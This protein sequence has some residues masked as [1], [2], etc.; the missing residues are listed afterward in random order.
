M[1]KLTKT[2][3]V[4][5]AVGFWAGG[6]SAVDIAFGTTTTRTIAIQVEDT[7][8][9]NVPTMAYP[10]NKAA[11]PGCNV[12]AADGGALFNDFDNDYSGTLSKLGGAT[13]WNVTVPTTTWAAVLQKT[14]GAAGAAVTGVSK[15]LTLNFD[16]GSLAVTPGVGADYYAASGVFGPF[17]FSLSGYPL[18]ADKAWFG[19]A[20]NP[21]VPDTDG[22]GG[23]VTDPGIPLQLSC[24]AGALMNACTAPFVYPGP[25]ACVPG[26]GAAVFGPPLP[27]ATGGA[28]CDPAV[29][30]ITRTQPGY[31]ASS[32]ITALVGSH[33]VFT[34]GP[35]PGLP[36]IQPAFAPLDWKLQEQPSLNFASSVTRTVI[37]Q[38]EDTDCTNVPTMPYP[39]NK[40]AAP[41]CNVYANDAPTSQFTDHEDDYYGTLSFVSGTT[42][43]LA[44]STPVWSAVLQATLGASGAAVTGVSKPMSLNFD[45]TGPVAPT[46]APDYYA[47]TGVFG[48]FPFSLN[49]YPLGA[50]KAWFGQADNPLVPDTDGMGGP[51]TD[52]GIPLQLSC[53]AG[54]LMNACTAP[55][56]YPGPPACVPGFG[57]A[58]FGPPLPLATG[59]APCDP[60]VAP[61]TRT[62]PGFAGT[63]LT[64]LVG[65]HLVFTGGPFPGLPAIQPAFAPLD[66]Q[67]LEVDG[68]VAADT[69]TDTIP[70]AFDNCPFASNV[71][72]TDTGSV[73]LASPPDGIGDA[74]QCGD[75]NNDGLVTGTDFILLNRS[76]L[77]LT[78][79]GS[80]PGMPGYAKCD[81]NGS[82]PA[83]TSTDG[84]LINR[85]VLNLPPG[86]TQTCTAADGSPL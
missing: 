39:D 12:Y 35:F 82:T 80:L 66:L 60:A 15:T 76:A 32:L 69:D 16:T 23:P 33:L 84:I 58:V 36:A 11:A 56:V 25:P 22:M 52:P 50:D 51:V 57:A 30:P 26:F 46:T 7:P 72:Q 45:T 20:D 38:T 14:L 8:C 63:A 83:C 5:A 3:A 71:A 48:P 41:G 53:A 42:W 78:P 18:G 13:D 75:I 2:L 67:L 73:G 70:N 21:L 28:P 54:A 10:D 55:F 27:A 29:A 31:T 17:P 81:V 59:G 64:G 65:S 47:A 68:V 6:A 79:Y 61:I 62:Q 74:C 1:T 49:G 44:T 37:V 40:A 19:Q 24:A 86:I 77:L 4:A 43:T 34:G 9:T 85:R